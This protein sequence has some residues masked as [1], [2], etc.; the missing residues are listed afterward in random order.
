[1]WAWRQGEAEPAGTPPASARRQGALRSLVGAA[2]GTALFL[3]WSRIVGSLVLG[4][5]A[6]L[7]LAALIS[8]GG[9]YAGLDRLFAATGRVVGRAL[10]WLLMVPLFY[11]FFLPFGLLFR[12][13]R[14][15][16]LARFIDADADTYW[17]AHAGPRAG[18]A[19]RDRQY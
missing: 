2:I 6:A 14:R 19:H 7:L 9:L 4:L 18:S 13:A 8:P 17:E 15:D 3:L 5:A 10:T 16:R 12:R 11:L 1:V